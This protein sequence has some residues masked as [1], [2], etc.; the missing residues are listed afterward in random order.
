MAIGRDPQIKMLK[1]VIK[2]MNQN[3]IE[4]IKLGQIEIKKTNFQQKSMTKLE[5]NRQVVVTE[6]EKRRLEEEELFWSSNIKL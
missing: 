1:Q 6:D 4:F 3:K 5:Q 2:L